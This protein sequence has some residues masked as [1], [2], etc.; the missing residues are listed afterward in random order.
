MTKDRFVEILSN[1]HVNNNENI[2]QNN[3]DKLFKLRPM[4]D[5]LNQIFLKSSSGTR[6]LS[7]DESM[8]KFKDCNQNG[9]IMKFSVYQGKNET[10]EKQ[11]ENTNL[12]ERIVLQLT[13]PFW[14]E[15]RLVFFDNYFTTIP[16]LEKL[17]TQHT[18]ACGIGIFKWKDN[19]VVHIA[20]NYH[21]NEKT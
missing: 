1:I 18:L 19:K 12:G 8:I 7:V 20:S 21:G 6:E 14:N 5:S 13:K 11:F 9:Y 3:K 17:K 2:P 4:I 16:L 10:L 15:S